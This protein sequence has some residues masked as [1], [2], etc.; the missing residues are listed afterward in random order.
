MH[1][2]LALFS[3]AMRCTDER[4]G[5]FATLDTII[6]VYIDCLAY[7]TADDLCIVRRKMVHA[8][9]CDFD[10]DAINF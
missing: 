6:S 8:P 1:V 5:G 4:R 7:K 3:I 9:Y 2:S 10:F